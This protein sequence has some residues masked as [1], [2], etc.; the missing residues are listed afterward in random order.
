MQGHAPTFAPRVIVPTRHHGLQKRKRRCRL[1]QRARHHIRI[2]S[3]VTAVPRIQYV[4][5]IVD[6]RQAHAQLV[7]RELHRPIQCIHTRV[8]ITEALHHENPR[9]NTQSLGPQR[10]PA[11]QGLASF[12][13]QARAIQDEQRSALHTDV[14]RV[15]HIACG[16][17]NEGRLVL[18]LIRLLDQHLGLSTIPCARPVLVRPHDAKVLVDLFFHKCVQRRIHQTLAIEPV[19][20]K[21]ERIDARITRQTRLLV[22]HRGIVQVIKTEITRDARL[23][24]TSKARGA[25]RHIAPL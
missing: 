3:H 21:A 19:V 12:G 6:I 15:R 5:L 22:Q 20:V 16:I 9:L 7:W 1:A 14:A 24:V 4:Q 10:A 18:L 2:T 11:C 8:L 25:A 13:Q 23:V 17:G